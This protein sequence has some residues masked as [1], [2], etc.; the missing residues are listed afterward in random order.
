M[1]D[2][3]QNDFQEETLLLISLGANQ[4][5]EK[6]WQHW[7]QMF[8]EILIAVKLNQMSETKI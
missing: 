5:E 1:L 6:Y 3:A 8:F 2:K 4:K 7:L